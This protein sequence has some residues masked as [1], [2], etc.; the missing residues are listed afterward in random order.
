MGDEDR[1]MFMGDLGV[2][3]FH[4]GPT[5]RAMFYGVG[6]IVF[7]TTG[8]DECRTWSIPAGCEAV[9]AAGCIHKDLSREV[10]P[11]Q[12]HQLRRLRRVPLLREGSEGA[13]PEPHGREELRRQGRRHHAH[14]GLEL[15]G[16]NHRGTETQ[17]SQ[18]SLDRIT[19]FT[20]LVLILVH[21][22]IPSKMPFAFLCVSV[23]LWL[24]LFQS[25]RNGFVFFS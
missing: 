16:T 21:P 3:E 20:V 14:P 17:R 5:I 9:E 12:R 1:Q 19:G 25:C 13:R 2:S 4:K 23:P 11:R 10:R 15:A 7:F 18:Q 6:R 22:V 8:E 24:A